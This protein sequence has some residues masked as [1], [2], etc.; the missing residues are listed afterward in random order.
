MKYAVTGNEMK[1]YDRN[2]SEYFGIPTFTLME[3]ASLQVADVIENWVRMRSSGRQHKALIFAGVGNNGGDGVC[4]AR[5]LKQRGFLV[6]VCVVGDYTKCSDLLLEQLKILEKYGT[7]TVTFSNIRDNKSNSQWDIIVDALFG[8]G[9]SRPVTGDYKEA[10]DYINRCKEERREDLFVISVDVP[11]GI[12]ADTGEVCQAAVKADATVTFNQTKLGHILYP[13]CEYCGELLVRD[14]G[15]TCDSFLGNEPHAFFYDEKIDELLPQRKRD[16]NKGTNGK[17]LVI[18]GS[19]E[20]S[21]AC[22]L[23]AKA[24][25]YTGCGMVKVLTSSQNAEAVKTLLPEAMLETYDAGEKIGDKLRDALKWSTSAVIGPGI[26]MSFRAG[27]MLGLVLEEYDKN[28]LID[29]DALNLISE[30]ES[31]RKLAQNYPRE[32]RKLILTPHLGEFARLYGLSVSECKKSILDYPVNLAKE[33]H[34]TVICKDARTIVTDSGE[35]KIYI[36]VSGNDG[37]ATA[38]SG[39]VL[40][41]IIGALFACGLSSFETACIG[42]YLHGLSGDRAAGKVGKHSM[43]ASDIISGLRD[44]L[45]ESLDT[46]YEPGCE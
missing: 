37:M 9:L 28:L 5:L 4:T 40:A 26:G 16:A 20:I 44:V 11:S 17:L 25:F 18:A 43:T 33:F 2:T 1:K 34:C 32:G 36:N 3:R 29:A 19:D 7:G 12:N 39:D 38:G 14:A 31:L 46:V 22:V 6:E 21:G 8:I 42:T 13:G 24:A 27:E 10:I 41:G 23:C 30:S 15:I 35:K 45:F